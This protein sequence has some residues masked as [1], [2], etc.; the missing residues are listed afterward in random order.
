MITNIIFAGVRGGVGTTTL[1]AISAALFHQA[2]AM[3]SLADHSEGRLDSRLAPPPGPLGITLKALQLGFAPEHSRTISVS[4]LDAGILHQP[5]ARYLLSPTTGLVLLASPDPESLAAVST[6]VELVRSEAGDGG[7]E[8]CR[9]CVVDVRQQRRGLAGWLRRGQGPHPSGALPGAAWL[10][11]DAELQP[12]G[13][14]PMETL[15]KRKSGLLPGTA[16]ILDS[17]LTSR[18]GTGLPGAPMI[19]EDVEDAT[20]TVW[21]SGVAPGQARY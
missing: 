2:G 18:V 8:R 15:A 14:V 16:A 20:G 9:P 5:V 7:A 17:V 4:L 11:F 10:P 3:V 1:T 19:E 12:W 13:P 6:A 21:L